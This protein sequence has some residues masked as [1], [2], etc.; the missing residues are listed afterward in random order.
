MAAVQ[1]IR[2]D[3]FS[4]AVLGSKTPVVVKFHAEY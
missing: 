4:T 3:Q 1:D 2:D